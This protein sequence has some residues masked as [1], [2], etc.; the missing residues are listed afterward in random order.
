[1]GQPRPLFAGLI[2][3]RQRPLFGGGAT[4]RKASIQMKNT[5]TITGKGNR[6]LRHTLSVSFWDGQDIIDVFAIGATKGETLNNWYLQRYGGSVPVGA[7]L[8]HERDLISIKWGKT[9]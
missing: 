8:P 1:M 4:G 6:A 3:S 7:C 9:E 5:N 2:A